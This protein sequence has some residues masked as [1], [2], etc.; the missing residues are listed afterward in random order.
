[1]HWDEEYESSNRQL[2]FIVQ[3]DQGHNADVDPTSFTFSI[4]LRAPKP[5]QRLSG[6]AEPVTQSLT[7]DFTKTK[8]TAHGT[9]LPSF[10]LFL[11]AHYIFSIGFYCF[12]AF[13]FWQRRKRGRVMR[14]HIQRVHVSESLYTWVPK[15]VLGFKNW[16]MP[17]VDDLKLIISACYF[18]RF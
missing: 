13:S 17:W 4:P 2:Q 15:T 16:K 11:T 3:R 9:K 14:S 1:M 12:L 10:F 6:V 18:N 5:K 8:H 7:M